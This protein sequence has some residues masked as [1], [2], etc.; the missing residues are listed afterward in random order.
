MVQ[1]MADIQIDIRNTSE[2]DCPENLHGLANLHRLENLH[3]FHDGLITPRPFRV[4]MLGIAPGQFQRN[5]NFTGM[6]FKNLK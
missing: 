4:A 2:L 3:G 1:K 5:A 6:Q